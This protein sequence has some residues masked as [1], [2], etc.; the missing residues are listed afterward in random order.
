MGH[1]VQAFVGSKPLLESVQ[2]R[3]GVSRVVELEQGLFLLPLTEELYDALPSAPAA[4]EWA[5]E[6]HFLF[7]DSKVVALLK[8][9]SQAES[10]AYV[11][12]EYF[13]GDGGQG[14]I[15]A[16]GGEIVLGPSKGDGSINAALNLLGA[17]KAGA[18]DE[19]EAVGL[20][21]FRSNDDWIE[22]PR[23]GR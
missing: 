21:R 6:F 23:Y 8:E 15:V 13:G 3:F 4:F 12:T 19:F 7:L 22:Q 9:A 14:A 1:Y 17:K 20:G 16:R 5:G 10:L 11:E 18:H 2:Q